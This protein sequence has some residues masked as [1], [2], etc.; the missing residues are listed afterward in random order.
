MTSIHSNNRPLIQPHS[1]RPFANVAYTHVITGQATYKHYANISKDFEKNRPEIAEYIRHRLEEIAELSHFM[2]QFMTRAQMYVE[3]DLSHD[4]DLNH[5]KWYVDQEKPV[6]EIHIQEFESGERS[7]LL[8][9]LIPLYHQLIT[10]KLYCNKSI[11]KVAE[12]SIEKIHEETLSV[13][14]Y[15]ESRDIIHEI[16]QR[17]KE[18]FSDRAAY[19]HYPIELVEKFMRFHSFIEK[20]KNELQLEKIARA[21]PFLSCGFLSN[22]DDHEIGYIG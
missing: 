14:E 22:F 18:Q 3:H 9:I 13:K 8:P 16:F 11:I 15:A 10:L 5:L 20:M 12:Q 2:N 21:T 6:S 7:N 1:N 19:T 4:E 17:W